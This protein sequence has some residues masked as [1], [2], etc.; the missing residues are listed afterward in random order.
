MKKDS[1]DRV[2]LIDEL[3]GLAIF[4]MVVY[5]T[6]F[7]LVILFGVDIPAF[8]S[9]F[10]QA[11]VFFFAGLFIFISGASCQ[12]SRNNLKRGAICF[13]FG[14]V[15]TIG[16]AVFAPGELILFGILHLLGL[17]MMLFP[18]L[19]P[20]LKK[21]PPLWGMIGCFLLFALTFHVPEGML[22][23]PGFSV[24]IPRAVYDIKWLFWLGFPG[25]DFFS[26]D[27]FS[28]F[29]WIF[30][31][32]AGSF[33]GRPVREH[34]MPAWIYASHCPPLAFLG[35]NT[36]IIYLFHQPV[37]LGILWVIFQILPLVS[38]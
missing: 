16:T 33:F 22:G 25:P 20:L 32:L 9:S 8:Y 12:F 2:H 19:S 29:P 24:P 5:H 30:C 36:L 21:I 4:L 38:R 35:R 18:L 6:F 17:C 27:Y 7:D 31:F 3:R 14:L 26:G 23:L 34:R 1:P 28:I 13:G 37:V 10:V 15:M 11:L